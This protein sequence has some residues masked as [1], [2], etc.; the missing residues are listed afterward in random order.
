MSTEAAR[1]GSTDRGRKAQEER[2]NSSTGLHGVDAGANMART[3]AAEL[4]GTFVLVLT[5]ISVAVA[6]LLDRATAGLAYDSLAIALAFGLALAAVVASIA[7]VSGAHVN[8]AVTLALAATK[9]LP[10]SL[11]PA[12]VGAQ[13]GGGVLAALVTWGVFGSSARGSAGGFLASTSL[14]SGVS[15]GQALLVEAV[16]TFILMFVVMSVA[17]DPRVDE[18]VAPVGIGFAL[19]CGVFIAGPIS[20]GA[21]N[22]ARALGP[23]IVSGNF[24]DVWIYI[25]GPV[26]GAV[27]AAFLYDRFIGHATEPGDEP[28]T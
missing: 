10:W 7:H 20:G 27:A 21:V 15:T 28:V 2:K 26:I 5:G 22:P 24:S 18:G 11:V 8:P 1:P 4:I 3:A 19:A 6:A 23:M 16:V 13:L 12:Y 9:K 25:L 17:T 14:G